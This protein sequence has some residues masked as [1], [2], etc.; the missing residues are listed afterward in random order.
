MGLCAGRPSTHGGQ[1]HR[2]M[3]RNVIIDDVAC[4]AYSDTRNAVEAA[5]G[6]A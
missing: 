5:T 6:V 1:C 3:A 2:L 4:M